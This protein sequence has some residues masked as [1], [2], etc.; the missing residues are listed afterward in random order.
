MQIWAWYY[1]TQ[2]DLSDAEKVHS[3]FDRLRR[4]RGSGLYVMAP[5]ADVLDHPE[6]LRAFLRVAR[7]EEIEA[8]VGLCPFSEPPGMTIEM[9]RR[10]YR[11][12]EQGEA[13]HHGLC[14]AWPENRLLAL[15]RLRRL[16]ETFEPDA[17]H[18]DYVR[19]C[20][21][22]FHGFAEDLE[23]ETG[24]K[25]LDTYHRCQCPLCQSERLA[26]LGRE[27]TCWDEQH[28]G[29]IYC[30]L[31]HRHAAITGFL[32]QLRELRAQ[33]ETRLSIAAR[34]QYLNRALIEGQ[35][36]VAWARQGLVDI[37]SP[38]NYSPWADV[39]RGRLQENQRLL[40]QAPVTVLEGLG[41][42]SSAGEPTPEEFARQVEVVAEA[43]LA[44]V[45]LFHLD[46]LT[47]WDCDMLAE[48]A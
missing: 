19:Y 24:R 41:R 5:E 25:W 34:V 23:W 47:D 30:I 42:K 11:Y 13:K 7:D 26:L 3:V 12:V 10:R 39:V 48:H 21:A 4:M 27:A 37:I 28:P 17:L 9:E 29:F 43:G 44:G 35:D 32:R 40:G 14:P 36:W 15:N 16:M 38:M 20:F 33:T 31:E 18:L 1:P 2:D 6:A 46:H 8:H 45:A 22:N